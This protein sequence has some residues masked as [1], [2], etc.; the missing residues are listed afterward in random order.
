MM[1][2]CKL[3]HLVK[4]CSGAIVISTGVE[5]QFGRGLDMGSVCFFD[6]LSHTATLA[7]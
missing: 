7:R 3:L 1:H 5:M 4:K 2:P 6:Y